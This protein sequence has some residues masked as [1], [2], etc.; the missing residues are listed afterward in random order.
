MHR[1]NFS[2]SPF[3]RSGWYFKAALLY[4]RSS[5]FSEG[6]FLPVVPPPFLLDARRRGR[7]RTSRRRRRR[8][9][10][11]L[12]SSHIA[13]VFVSLYR[14]T[15]CALLLFFA[16]FFFLFFFFLSFF[17][18]FFSFEK[19]NSL[20]KSRILFVCLHFSR[21]RRV[22]SRLVLSHDGGRLSFFLSFF[23]S[24]VGGRSGRKSGRASLLS[25]SPSVSVYLLSVHSIH[26][27]KGRIGKLVHF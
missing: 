13:S 21:S 20:E 25:P 15:L 22:S 2:A 5:V 11:R 24:S 9:Q 23:L 17:C 8:R 12:S 19:N 6:K 16:Y 18:L 4:A 27:E 10:S 14:K 7:R 3:G 26:R 1:K